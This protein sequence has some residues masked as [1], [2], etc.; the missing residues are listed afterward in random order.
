MRAAQYFSKLEGFFSEKRRRKTFP[1]ASRRS[2]KFGLESLEARVLLSADLGGAMAV[3]D[4][5]K[6]STLG[7][8]QGI[9]QSVETV[10][11]A[12]TA[13]PFSFVSGT[14]NVARARLETGRDYILT[15]D[16]GTARDT[17][18]TPTASQL[19]IFEDGRELG[20]AHSVHADI[21]NLGQGRFSY[22]GG[23]DGTVM[24]LNFSASDNTNPMTNGRSYTYQVGTATAPVQASSLS[25]AQTPTPV[26]TPSSVQTTGQVF[27]ISPGGSDSNAGTATAPW[28]SIQTAAQRLRAGETAILMDG[29]YEEG[30]IWFQNSGTA[31]NPIT[32]QAQNKWGAVLSS[33]SGN[34]PAISIAASYITI[35]D[36]RFSVSPNNVQGNPPTNTSEAVRLWESTAPS[37]SNPHTGFQGCVVRGVLIDY[38]T[39]RTIGIK[40]NQDFTLVENNVIYSS[41]E[42]FNNTGTIFRGNTIYGA[43]DWNDYLAGK[44]GIRDLQIY[45]NVVHLTKGGGTGISIGGW[46]GIQW[47][48]DPSTAIE[49]YNSVVY[50]NVVIN[51]TGNPQLL[52]MGL[53]GTQNCALVNNVGING[54]LFLTLGA[55][56][57]SPIRPT[58]T[59]PTFIN[60]ILRGNGS[61]SAT[62]S[63]TGWDGAWNGTLTMDHN[64]FSN[65]TSVPSQTN[66]VAGN[67]L[68]VNPNSDWHV[69]TG[70]PTLS[71]GTPVSFSGFNGQPIDISQ[72]KDG[73]IR[74]GTWNLGL[75]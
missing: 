55:G 63:W 9:I 48:F 46:S 65:F 14:I 53:S 26:Q 4:I 52:L 54:P 49:A 45:N 37:P 2:S 67:P 33:L 57:G 60:N 1:R 34:R 47:V 66:P 74:P 59:N 5:L 72:N 7:T 75:Y 10:K 70:S 30:E 21:A 13:P 12:P 40:T 42:A 50:N 43:D 8:Q 56:Q 31:G 24:N 41:V 16:F 58:N 68:F 73:N 61:N 38:S 69:Q 6:S 71:S 62:G 64:N 51:E 25:S 20:P 39:Q 32:L 19:R 22:W 27:Y 17:P 18:T 15:Q 44:G 3:A 36:I 35:E 29:T 28:H 11:T 23:S